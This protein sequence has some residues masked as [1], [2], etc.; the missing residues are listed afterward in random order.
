M[1]TAEQ[2]K[3]L[4]DANIE[5]FAAAIWCQY[6]ANLETPPQVIQDDAEA[7][8]EVVRRPVG[9]VAAITP[10]NFPL[11]LA[12]WKIARPCWPATPWSS[13]PRPSPRWPR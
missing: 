11:T 4:G 1:L 3:P 13:S 9:V 10:W 5:V 2:G 8:V 12:F 7:L 6:Y